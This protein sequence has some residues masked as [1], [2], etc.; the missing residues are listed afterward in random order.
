MRRWHSVLF[1]AATDAIMLASSPTWPMCLIAAVGSWV[2]M[3][4]LL[5]DGRETTS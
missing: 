2:V 3:S 1:V 5:P 4:L